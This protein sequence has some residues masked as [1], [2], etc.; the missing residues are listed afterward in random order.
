MMNDS[1]KLY[2]S[3]YFNKAITNAEHCP[4]SIS[5]SKPRWPLAFDVENKL[6]I[7]APP[8]YLLKEEDPEVYRKEYLGQLE[9]H[10]VEKIG[11]LLGRMA[12]RANGRPL[13]LLC[14]EDLRKGKWCH[15]RMF[16][17]WWEQETGQQVEELDYPDGPVRSSGSGGPRTRKER[18][19]AAQLS[20]F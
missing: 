14:W 4:V 7:L 17:E 11:N 1:L 18:R 19:E 8:G 16:A 12:E 3:S 6:S 13:V 2:T 10:G 15:R 9:H 20:L 5:V